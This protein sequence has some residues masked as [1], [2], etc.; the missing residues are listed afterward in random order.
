MHRL[1]GHLVKV[2]EK[3]AKVKGL[4]AFYEMKEAT[5]IF[6]LALWKSRI[7]QADLSSPS[8]R[9][10]CRTEVPGPVKDTIL[11]YLRGE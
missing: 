5:I 10:A 8:D 3:L 7:D 9:R 2:A 11:Q 4:I 1:G 6:E